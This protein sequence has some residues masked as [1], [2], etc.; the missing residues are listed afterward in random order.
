MCR[1]IFADEAAAE[2]LKN[3]FEVDQDMP[4]TR[5][6]RRVVRRMD[7]VLIE[8][9]RIRNFHRHG[10]NLYFDSQRFQ[11]RHKFAVEAHHTPRGKVEQFGLAPAGLNPQHMLDEVKFHLKNPPTTGNHG[12]RQAASAHIEG[13][14]PPVVHM[15][16]Q[17]QPNFANDLRP[18]V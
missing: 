1:A 3:R 12:G 7:G 17:R 2:L 5:C 8:P 11:S 6:V 10:P 18:H 16:A 15:G 14:F 9:N 4:E 13:N